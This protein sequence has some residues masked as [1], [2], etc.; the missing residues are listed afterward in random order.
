MAIIFHDH[1]EKVKDAIES[2]ALSALDEAAGEL[3]SRVKQNTKVRTGKTKNSWEYATG[4]D[5]DNFMAVIGSNY[6]NAIW[7]EFGTGEYALN[8]NG[9][10]GGWAYEDPAT[11]ERIWTRGK[12]PRRAFHNAYTSMKDKIVK[13]IQDRFKGGLS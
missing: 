1:T 3:T 6:E 13:F 9:R 5:G 12:R 8:G 7:E 10:K 2:L 4:N 11:G